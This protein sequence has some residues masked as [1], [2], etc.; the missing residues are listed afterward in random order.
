M[1][2][3]SEMIKEQPANFGFIFTNY[4]EHEIKDMKIRTSGYDTGYVK[5]LKKDY[6]IG[7]L[8]KSTPQTGPGIFSGF[9]IVGVIVDG[10]SQRYDFKP[11]IDYCYTATT[12]YTK[13]ICVPSK[14][15]LCNVPVENY[16][17][18][19]GPLSVSIDRVTGFD[20]KIRIDFKILNSINGDVVNECFDNDD[21][22]NAYSKPVVKLGS[23]TGSCQAVSGENIV[24][25]KSNFYCEFSRSGGE[26][27]Y[28][29]Q[30]VVQFNYLYQQ[31][32]KKN[33]VVKDLN[34][35]Y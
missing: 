20:N 8:P 19:N 15:N 17:N 5:G 2:P 4:Q 24:N 18:Q 11:K 35:G 21:Y 23:T 22:I 10:F 34:N 6:T 33:I 14:K 29:S 30:V 9:Q 13:Q 32:I 7:T 16:E 3:P 27:S 31:S 25:G 28:A 26:D 1:D 12:T